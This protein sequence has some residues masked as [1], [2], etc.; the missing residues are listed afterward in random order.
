MITGLVI[1]VAAGNEEWE[2]G[3]QGRGGAFFSVFV[4]Y[5]LDFFF[6]TPCA[7]FTF[8]NTSEIL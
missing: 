1:L 4:A 6:F 2:A 3:V 8:L 7:C 5:S